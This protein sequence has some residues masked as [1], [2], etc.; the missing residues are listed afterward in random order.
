M[1]SIFDFSRRIS[2]LSFDSSSI[3][4][5][6]NVPGP[7]TSERDPASSEATV[8]ADMLLIIEDQLEDTA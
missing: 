8:M 5:G 7:M 1:I 4:A 2:G 3:K 6:R